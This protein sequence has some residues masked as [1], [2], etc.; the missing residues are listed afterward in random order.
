MLVSLS[1][2]EARRVY[3]EENEALCVLRR[4]LETNLKGLLVTRYLE[5]S[6]CVEAPMVSWLQNK[7]SC[8]VK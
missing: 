6:E 3:Q 1:Q 5:S 7:L 4:I 8:P 2:T